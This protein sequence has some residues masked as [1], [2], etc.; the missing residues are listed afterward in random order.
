MIRVSGNNETHSKCARQP[1][2]VIATLS[3]C[4]L[5]DS[6]LRVEQQTSLIFRKNFALRSS[7]HIARLKL[8]HVDRQQTDAM[9]IHPAQIR[10]DQ[11]G[12]GQLGSD[13]RHSG[14]DQYL[15]RKAIQFIRK[16]SR[17]AFRLYKIALRRS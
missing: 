2:G 16:D 1:D 10:G 5:P 15:T 11:G 4:K 6:V 7:V 13:P 3:G 9:R 12:T 17:H 14:C 8:F